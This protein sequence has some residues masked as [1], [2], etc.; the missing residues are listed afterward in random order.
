MESTTT[1]TPCNG[2]GEDDVEK[3]A[4][5]SAEIG[6]RLDALRHRELSIPEANTPV[7]ELRDH[8]ADLV[9]NKLEEIEGLKRQAEI[10]TAQLHG[11]LAMLRPVNASRFDV[12]TLTFYS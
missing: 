10:A 6:P 2:C 12:D 4:K 8:E 5:A 7:K 11:M 1:E 3:I 9:K